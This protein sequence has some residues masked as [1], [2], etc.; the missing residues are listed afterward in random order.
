MMVR[1][2][3]GVL[4]A[5][6]AIVMSLQAWSVVGLLWSCA[7]LVWA[8]ARPRGGL[9]GL[10]ALPFLIAAVSFGEGALDY[11]RGEG[12]RISLGLGGRESQNLDRETRMQRRGRCVI[13]PYD[14]IT[15]QPYDFALRFLTAH[16][17]L[18]SGAY[19]GPY[20]TKAEAL[21][22]VRER[23][24]EVPRKEATEGRVRTD[25]NEFVLGSQAARWVRIHFQ[26]DDSQPLRALPLGSGA[27]LVG[28]TNLVVLLDVKNDRPVA[29]WF[30]ENESQ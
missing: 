20:P 21:S 23:G 30:Y 15:R 26:N 24:T 10:I 14:A 13:S 6:C 18:M 1:R 25:G 7:A 28:A 27:L 12:I 29:R 2:I 4:C 17:G 8:W 5:L 19:A 3:G 22:L 16:F 9:I 11:A